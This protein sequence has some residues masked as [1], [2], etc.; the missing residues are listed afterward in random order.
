MVDEFPRPPG[1]S[2]QASPQGRRSPPASNYPDLAEEW[3]GQRRADRSSPPPNSPRIVNGPR[4][5]SAPGTSSPG[6]ISPEWTSSSI[7]PTTPQN[8]RPSESMQLGR[9]DPRKVHAQVCGVARAVQLR[10]QSDGKH[11]LSF[12]VERYDRSGNRLRPVPVELRGNELSGQLSDGDEVKVAGR[13]RRGTIRA[14]TVV[15]IT[16]GAHVRAAANGWL[17]LLVLVALG[18]T[19]TILFV[20]GV[21]G[22]VLDG[23]TGGPPG[24]SVSTVRVPDVSGMSDSAAIRSLNEAGLRWSFDS[25]DSDNV[26]WGKVIRT[27]PPAGAE[28]QKDK[29]VIVVTSNRPPFR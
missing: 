25:E 18:I 24:E 12:R 7:P 8:T 1:P 10:T 26:P 9:S 20:T 17:G 29:T 5:R 28:V 4:S 3:T 23:M 13:W 15:N 19:V 14:R 6:R 22:D 16:T 21:M 2:D 11:V 27:D